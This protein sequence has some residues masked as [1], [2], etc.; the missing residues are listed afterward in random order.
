MTLTIM[1]L[2]KKILAEQGMEGLLQFKEAWKTYHG[3]IPGEVTH[4][5]A[6]HYETPANRDE[7]VIRVGVIANLLD[8]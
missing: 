5:I 6:V 3:L 2:L 4:L 1:Q 7:M 8:L